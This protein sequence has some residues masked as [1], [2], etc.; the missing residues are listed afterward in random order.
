MSGFSLHIPR[1]RITV[2]TVDGGNAVAP[3]NQ[4]W[5]AVGTVHPGERVDLLVEWMDA[6]A[7]EIILD[8]EYIL[9]VLLH[10]TL[11]LTDFL[12]TTGQKISH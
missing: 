7:F 4:T 10:F 6:D 1:A 9:P 3:Q 5:S 2:L 12:D 11:C 8:R